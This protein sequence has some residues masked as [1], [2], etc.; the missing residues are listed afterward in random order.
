MTHTV[1]SRPAVDSASTGGAG[2]ALAAIVARDLS[3]GAILRTPLLLDLVFG[4]VNL[5]VFLFISRMLTHAATYFDFVAIGITFML[6]V[7][8]ACLQLVTKV[9]R[10]QIAGTL[11]MLTVQPVRTWELAVGLG[12]Y[13]IISAL[14]RAGAYLAILSLVLGLHVGQAS[15]LGVVTLLT[16]SSAAVLG[17]GIAL[18]A[19]AL[20][21]GHGTALARVVVVGLSFVSGTYFPA[22]HLP[23][24]VERLA[25][26]LPT[27]IALD[28]LRA[29]V[30]GDP[31]AGAAAALLVA[32]V[33]LLPLSVWMFGRAIKIAGRRGTMTHD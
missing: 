28:G 16:V 17:I 25:A 9:L 3:H 8:A 1:G 33:V 29:A 18:A 7:Q 20:V 32:S 27:R 15:W 22:S 5:V 21:I 14:V 31:W 10:E 13:P 23:A 26:V 12:G 11:E 30:A 24:P 2:R 4:V 19:V 6:V